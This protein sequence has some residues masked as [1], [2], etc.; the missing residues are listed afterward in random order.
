MLACVVGKNT[1][2]SC[3]VWRPCKPTPP[4]SVCATLSRYGRVSFSISLHS[5]WLPIAGLSLL[6]NYTAESHCHYEWFYSNALPKTLLFVRPRARHESKSIV[7]YTRVISASNTRTS[8][9]KHARRPERVSCL[10]HSHGWPLG[11]RCGYLQI[12]TRKKTNALCDCF[13]DIRLID[14]VNAVLARFARSDVLQTIGIYNNKKKND[15]YNLKN[16]TWGR[17]YFDGTGHRTRRRETPDALLP[18]S[19][20]SFII[21]NKK[22]KMANLPITAL[23]TSYW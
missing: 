16:N 12:W 19:S 15:I 3:F 5:C 13:N 14:N 23:T 20:L 1:S 7:R 21:K 10:A 4:P 6:H 2:K 9:S 11:V 18:P 8:L 22:E 17:L